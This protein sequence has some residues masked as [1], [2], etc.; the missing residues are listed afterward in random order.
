[1]EASEEGPFHWPIS[2]HWSFLYPLETS[3][4]LWFSDVF[5]GYR[6][7]PVKWSGLTSIFDVLAKG[8]WEMGK[9]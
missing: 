3:V 7:T 6:K 1:M 8:Y 9:T 4:N 5:R 2:Y